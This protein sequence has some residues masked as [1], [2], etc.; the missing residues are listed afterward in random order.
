MSRH[1]NLLP[2]DLQCRMLRDQRL[3]QWAVS[4]LVIGVFGV[5][6][7]VTQWWRLSKAGEEYHS[8]ERRAESVQAIQLASQNLRQKIAQQQERLVKYGHLEN[9]KL[10]FQLLGTL[11]QAASSCGGKIQVQKMILKTNQVAIA[12][13]DKPGTA[14]PGT[15]TP[16]AAAPGAAAPTKFRDVRVLTLAGVAVN[17]LAVAQLVSALRD[18]GAFDSVEL[19]TSQSLGDNRSLALPV[20][21]T[22]PNGLRT[23]QVECAF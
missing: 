5:T 21:S 22:T 19:R 8:W 12:A 17:N 1:L 6:V 15:A 3:R 14:I 7:S 20:S 4:W 13:A 16:G 18:S 10:G 11:S 9:E 23:Y 2:W